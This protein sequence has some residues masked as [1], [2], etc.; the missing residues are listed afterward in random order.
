PGPGIRLGGMKGRSAAPEEEVE[1]VTPIDQEERRHHDAGT[2]P[3]DGRDPGANVGPF[4]P[5]SWR[6]SLLRGGPDRPFLR[7][8]G[9]VT[10]PVKMELWSRCVSGSV[11]AIELRRQ[12]A[13]PVDFQL[14]IAAVGDKTAAILTFA[15]PK[16]IGGSLADGDYVLTVHADRVHDRWGREL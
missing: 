7:Q 2:T 6:R 13:S 3:Q 10:E 1:T 8:P 15:G 9:L 12:D 4:A 5:E 14:A 11:N 16:F